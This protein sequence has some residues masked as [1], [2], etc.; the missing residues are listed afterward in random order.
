MSI[1]EYKPQESLG[2]VKTV[3]TANVVVS[4]SNLELLRQLQVNRLVALQSSKP[5]QHL[6]G[7]VQKIT[8]QANVVEC[9]DEVEDAL[10]MR[11]EV[12]LVRIALIGTLIDQVGKSQ[13]VFRRTLETVPEIEAECYP[14]EKS[15]LTLF[16]KVLSNLGANEKNKLSLGTYTL[17]EDAEAFL[18]GNKLFQRHAVVVGST[19]S[20]KSWTTA[21]LIE[22]IAELPQA[23]AVL[24]DIHGEYKTLTHKGIRQLRI[25]GPG[26]NTS[27]LAEGV[28]HLPYWLLGYEDMIA[29]LLDRS[30]QNAP[31]QAMI[32]SRSV[33]AAKRAYLER[34]KARELLADFTIDSPVPYEIGEV[35]SELQQLDSEMVEGSRG[36]KQG[37]FY[38]K[39]SRFLIRLENK[40]TDRRLSFLFGGKSD[41]KELKWLETLARLLMCG[42]LDQENKEGGVKIIDFSEVPSDILPLIAGLVARLIFSIQQ[43]TPSK[44]R[45]PIAIF[46]DEAHLYMPSVTGSD[47]ISSAGLRTF[48][49]I[50]KEGRKY[51]LGLIVI[52]QRPSEVSRTVLSQCSN[53]I[54]MRLS[55]AEDQLVVKRLLPDSLGGFTELLPVLDVGEALVVGDASLLPARVRIAKPVNHPNSL[56]VEFWDMWSKETKIQAISLAVHSLRRQSQHVGANG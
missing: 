46:C 6:I 13:N 48:E 53:F 30:D 49:R 52:S 12:N 50:A 34:A 42:S 55:N 45:H 26:D 2:T 37:E 14:I 36:Q 10:L 56:T 35:I 25:A 28:I 3:D 38:G 54:A 41:T 22:Q 39:L 7:M 51:G 15:R 11:N 9:A 1:L 23:N 31:N 18:N 29:M 44:S 20:G 4:V 24:F 19:G 32:F 27:G 43:W 16:M 17:D 5:G 33:L 21:R 40:I 47:A 8:R